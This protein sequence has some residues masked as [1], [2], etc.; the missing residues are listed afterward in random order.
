ML[1]RSKL[2]AAVLASLALVP[3]LAASRPACCAKPPV[4]Q[5]ATHACCHAAGGMQAAA[6]KPCCKAPVA[7]VPETKAKDAAPI[8][9]SITAFDLGAP[10]PASIDLPESVAV[11]CARRAHHAESPDDSPPDLL[12]RHHILLI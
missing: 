1:N 6:P 9:L 2:V 5:A 7:P 3:A 8:T 11:R 10:A 4:A 12:A